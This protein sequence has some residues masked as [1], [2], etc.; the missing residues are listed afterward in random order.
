MATDYN[1]ASAIVNWSD[2]SVSDNSGEL[3]MSVQSHMSGDMFRIGQTLVVYNATD[4]YNNIAVCSFIIYIYDDDDPNLQCPSDITT[5][6]TY[7]QHD[8]YNVTWSDPIVNDNSGEVIKPTSKYIS[9]NNAFNIGSTVVI[10][11]AVDSSG[12]AAMC[13]FTITVTDKEN[14]VINNCP[15]DTTVNTTTGLPTAN[16]SWIEPEAIDN[17]GYWGLTADIGPGSDFPIGN[18]VVTYTAEDPYENTATCSFTV[19]VEDNEA[20]VFTFCPDSQSV[21]TTNGEYIGVAAWDTPTASDNSETLPIIVGSHNTTFK[22]PAGNTLVKYAANDPYDNVMTCTFTI[23]VEDN[24]API[25]TSCPENIETTTDTITDSTT[26]TWTPITTATDNSG[27]APNITTCIEQGATLAIG[28]HTV[29]VTATDSSGNINATCS[30]NIEVLDDV[31]PVLTCPNDTLVMLGNTSSTVVVNWTPASVFDNSGLAI[32]L[33]SSPKMSGD[34][35]NIGTFVITYTAIDAFDNIATCTFTI[36]VRDLEL[37]YF[38]KCPESFTVGTDPGL[39]TANVSWVEPVAIDNNGI[40][41]TVQNYYPNQMYNISTYTVMYIAYDNSNNNATCEFVISVEDKELPN[42]ICPDNIT[43]ETDPGIALT[44]VT[45]NVPVPTDNVAILPTSVVAIPLVSPPVH[46]SITGNVA[47]EQA[48]TAEDTS[49]NIASCTFYI[50]VEGI[51]TKIHSRIS[52]AMTP[53]LKQ[54][55]NHQ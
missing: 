52:S 6:T 35:F 30:F 43:K 10:Y 7:G 20:P 45:W 42:I 15:I 29:D 53:D 19:T 51:V 14:P 44:L 55:R 13:K 22:F 26:V 8:T 5:N 39:A 50:T 47:Y 3:L 38:E 27:V 40:N 25:I 28:N 36:T 23:T 16:I 1:Q 9:G 2:P 21:N 41:R 17:S 12:N 18:I 31:P 24:E 11:D 54:Q 33:Y 48:Y 4:P 34:K 49:G 32:V 37:P 46:I